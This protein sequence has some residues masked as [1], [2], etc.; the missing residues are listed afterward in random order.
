MIDDEDSDNDYDD[1]PTLITRNNSDSDYDSNS[2]DE[3]DSN[4]K[5]FPA[6]ITK[7]KRRK[8]QF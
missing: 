1:M 8:L 2:E 4:M 6:K 7:E 3:Y 5:T